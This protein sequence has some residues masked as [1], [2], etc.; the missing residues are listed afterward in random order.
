MATEQLERVIDGD[1]HVMED[2]AGV[3]SHMSEVYQTTRRAVDPF[4]P[5][6]HLHS[7]NQHISPPG[8]FAP[9]QAD[10]WIE[11]LDDVGIDSTV[12][13]TTRGLSFGKVISRDW[14][15]ELAHAYNDWLYET[16]LS[17]NSRFKGMGLIPLQDPKEAAKE[18]RRIV[19]DYGMCGA[20][21]PS[22]GAAQ[23]H[24]GDERYWPIY[25]EASNLGCAI[26]I[27][28]GAHEN[29]GMDDLTPYAPVNALGHP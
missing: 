11:F 23:A 17:K 20:M 4:P 5:L 1:G 22:T 26:G 16:Y 15:I 8:S 14:A 18:L 2:L 10:G 24:L 13:Y 12:L 19:R 9:V 6:D 29:L 3:R 21:L 27:H 28:G 7:S 25:E